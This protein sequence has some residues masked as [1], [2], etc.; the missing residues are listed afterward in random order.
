MLRCARMSRREDT[1]HRYQ[2]HLIRLKQIG[3][4]MQT[5]FS[6][7]RT[8]GKGGQE[9]CTIHRWGKR[10]DSAACGAAA[11]MAGPAETSLQ[12][13]KVQERSPLHPIMLLSS[14]QFS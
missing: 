3:L 11:G 10:S 6:G 13:L 9:S 7:R 8:R 4:L 2:L 1:S 5:V 14:E 12:L